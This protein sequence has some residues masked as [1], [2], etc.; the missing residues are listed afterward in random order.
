MLNGWYQQFMPNLGGRSITDVFFLD[1]LTGWS[2]SNATNQNPDTT[3]VL[4][5]TNGGDNWVIQYRK[6][7]T[8]GGFPG[9]NKVYFLNQSTGFV[10]GVMGLDKSIDGGTSWVVL[11]PGDSYQ[12][13][14]ILNEDTIWLV[15][16]NPLTGGVFRT[17]NG[18]ASWD[19]QLN[20]GSQN[21]SKIYMY[22]ARIG[23][24]SSTAGL[25]KTTNGENWT[26]ASN[27][28]SFSDMF[29]MDSLTGWKASGF[30]KKTTDG[31]LNWIN[32]TI[33]TGGSILG[34]GALE[35]M[36]K[37]N[38]TIWTLGES[39]ITG[40]SPNTRGILFRTINSGNNWLF[41]L[42]DTSI[43]ITRYFNGQFV[44]DKIGWA[45]QINGIHTT[46]GGNDTFYTNIEQI[47][48]NVP[49]EFKLFQNYPN[50]FNPVTY[51]NYELKIT[52]YV[53]LRIFDITGKRITDLVNQKQNTGSYKITFDG[54]DYSSGVY[55]YSLIVDGKLVD[56]KKMILLK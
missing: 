30:I 45:Y 15:S 24:V 39:I 28:F 31:G 11:N 14:S 46:T 13:M 3:Y 53:V 52:N 9:Y 6:T 29:M 33:P 22:N 8:G 38:D 36:N 40:G 26:F 41:Q 16:G 42:P 37:D 32:Q 56:T 27:D 35:F 44:N 21:P 10:C 17:T 7:Q 1:S 47:S 25:Y 34:S 5:T 19:R 49:K 51:I 12:D 20:L 18:G 43:H 54:T 48:S 50:P 55:F 2:V 4:K 23:F